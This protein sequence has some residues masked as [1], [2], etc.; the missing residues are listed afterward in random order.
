VLI[1]TD[2]I[3]CAFPETRN[4]EVCARVH[5][6]NGQSKELRGD[7]KAAFDAWAKGRSVPQQHDGGLCDGCEALGVRSDGLVCTRNR[8]PYPECHDKR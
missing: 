7:A 8:L 6:K 1:D 2:E 3:V 5:F 4:E